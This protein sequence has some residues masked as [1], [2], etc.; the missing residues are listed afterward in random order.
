M[1]ATVDLIVS[2]NTMCQ[3]IGVSGDGCSRR[4]V[5]LVSQDTRGHGGWCPKV[6]GV[7]GHEVLQDTWC[8]KILGV[9]GD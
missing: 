1:L 6:L 8:H 3:D 2:Q 9:M 4:P 5:L 7:P